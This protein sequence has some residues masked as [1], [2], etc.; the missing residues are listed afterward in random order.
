M[1]AMRAPILRNEPAAIARAAA[2]L[3]RGGLVVF[4]TETVYGLGA[5]AFDAAAARRVYAAKGR[6][7][8]NPLIVHALDDAM[9]ARVAARLTPLARRL[10]RAFWPGPLTLVLDKADAVPLAVTAG[11]ATVAVRRPAHP[12]ARAL[13]RALGEPIAAPSANRSGRPSPTTAA[14][15][16]RDL[17]ARVALILDGGPCAEGLESAIVD[18]RGRRPVL[19]RPGTIPAAAIERAAGA[20]LAAPGRRAP[21]APGT[22]HR[23]YAPSCRVTLV[24][25]EDLRAGEPGPGPGRGL[26]HR[27]AA[28]ARFRGWRLRVRGGTAAYA[29]ALFAALRRAEDAGVREL[30]VETVP[31][32]GAGA[33]VMD[34]LRRAAS[35]SRAA[36]GR[37]TP[38]P[39]RAR[40]PR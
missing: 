9:V 16:A 23:H 8:D 24:A 11:K 14:H 35:A 29:K 19:L 36:S 13:L 22:R 37:G 26:V 32:T 28:G 6:P 3:R 1:E 30:F 39:R 34:R 12:A 18:A 40:S 27:S 10:M 7:S 38:R 15:A 20:R 2:V 21:A 4:P 17:G 31:E 5:R 25:A 33:A